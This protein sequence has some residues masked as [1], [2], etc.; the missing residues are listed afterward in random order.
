[1]SYSIRPLEKVA[2]DINIPADKSI[3]HRAII[4]ASI[5]EGKTKIK[6]FLD[7]DDTQATLSCLVSLGVNIERTENEIIVVGCG[8]YFPQP[9]NQPLE[10]NANESGTTMRILSGSLCAQKFPVKFQ[11]ALALRR[12]PMKRIIEPLGKMGAKIEGDYPPLLISPASGGLRSIDYNLPMASAQVKSAIM[13]AALYAQGETRIKEPYQSRDHTE[14]ML[15]LF[16]A[17]IK[18]EADRTIVCSPTEKLESPADVFIPSDF[19]SAAFFIVLGL[20]LKNSKLLINNV[21]LNPSRCGL[22]KVLARMGAQI[23]I[24]NQKE[25]YEPHADIVV[26]SSQLS[27]TTIEPEEIPSM[28]DEI[29]IISVAAA[30]AKGNTVIKGLEELRVKEA[31]RLESIHA[32]LRVAGVKTRPLGLD[33]IEITGSLA[34]NQASFDSFHDHRMAMSAVVLGSAIGNCQINDINCID[35]SFPGFISLIDSL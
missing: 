6:N 1:M 12:R 23:E 32:M 16:K 21:N 9:K 26:K 31:D 22:L 4:L 35:K 34:L 11:A 2:T 24:I 18:V 14:R 17:N 25:S 20:I 5:S 30:S 27:A 33:G 8:K 7:C 3:S 15:K 10:L 28:I 13:L 29:P 19:S